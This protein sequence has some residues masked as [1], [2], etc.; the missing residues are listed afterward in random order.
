MRVLVT[1]AGGYIGRHVVPQLI[2]RGADVLALDTK[3]PSSPI[4]GVT[5]KIFDFMEQSLSELGK[6]SCDTC[7]HLAWRNGFSHNADS[8]MLE[9]SSHYRFLN[10]LMEKGVERIVVMGTMHEVG[11]WE[12]PIDAETPCNPA[13]KYAIAKNALRQSLAVRSRELGRSLCWLR[14]FYIRGDDKFSQSIF[15]KI[16]RA[17]EA[18]QKTFPFTSGK[19]LYDF[20][21]VDE[22][23]AQIAA[24]T[25]RN[26]VNGIVNCCSGKPISLAEEIEGFLKENNLKISLA[27]GK[28]P[29]REYDSPGIWGNPTRINQIMADEKN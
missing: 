21:T 11:Y 19:N 3:E 8:H 7:L 13:S 14:G 23:G 6:I 5:W 22:L 20:I 15:G 12:G 24:C 25:V 27:Y 16:V 28:F 10:G 26:D 2:A 9:L 17:A 1:G 18:G 29:D 4:E